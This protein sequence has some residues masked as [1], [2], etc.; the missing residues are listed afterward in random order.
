[1][2]LLKLVILLSLILFL[3]ACAVDGSSLS[4]A[5]CTN[6]A[7]PFVGRYTGEEVLQGGTYPITVK[8]NCAGK[9]R[10]VDIDGRIAS[11]NLKGATF[12][13][14]RGGNAPQVFAGEISGNQITGTTTD[15]PFLGPGTFS[16]TRRP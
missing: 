6:E 8:I 9:V 2:R 4:S 5:D 3:I 7:N 10:L 16:A 12:V 15:N 1:M 13:A 14:R 11:G